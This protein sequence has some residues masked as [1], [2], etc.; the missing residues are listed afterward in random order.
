VKCDVAECISRDPKGLYRKALEG[1]ISNYTGISSPFE[2]AENPDLVIDTKNFS[3]DE[4]VSLLF[5]YLQK[6][7]FFNINES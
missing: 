7:R 4:S 1:T 5:D 2:E 3:I 6:H